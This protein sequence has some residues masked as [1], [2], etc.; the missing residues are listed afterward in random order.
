[1]ML[2]GELKCSV[3]FRMPYRRKTVGTSEF[4]DISDRRNLTN[5]LGVDGGE[6]I[7]LESNH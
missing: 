1:M 2:A 7:D 3:K 6:L 5:Y 4:T